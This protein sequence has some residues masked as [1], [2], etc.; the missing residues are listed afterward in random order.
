MQKHA[1]VL[2]GPGSP[3]NARYLTD[4]YGRIMTI[5]HYQTSEIHLLT[6]VSSTKKGTYRILQKSRKQ[7]RMG[8]KVVCGF[9]FTDNSK[10]RVTQKLCGII[11]LHLGL[12]TFRFHFPKHQITIFMIFG[13]TGHDADPKKTI[14]FDFGSTN[15]F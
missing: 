12:V 9:I 11:L 5:Q 13:I 6:G 4:P 3:G 14:V 15:L 1:I 2:S 8:S 7:K 10:I